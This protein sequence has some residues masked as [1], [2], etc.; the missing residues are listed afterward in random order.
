MKDKCY[1]I[2]WERQKGKMLKDGTTH[3]I[4]ESITGA[5]A[6]FQHTY[7][8]REITSIFIEGD[9]VLA[10]GTPVLK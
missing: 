6:L 4:A 1:S 10:A 2:S 8:E 5:I 3:V 7:K 9:E